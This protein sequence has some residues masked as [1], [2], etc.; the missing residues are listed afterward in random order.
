MNVNEPVWPVLQSKINVE[1]YGCPVDCAAVPPLFTDSAFRPDTKFT[2]PSHVTAV[3]MSPTRVK[4]GDAS[5][6]VSLVRWPSV[7][8]HAVPDVA[9]PVWAEQPIHK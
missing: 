2:L 6:H 5:V 4:P 9:Q 1:S 8:E 7:V 3:A